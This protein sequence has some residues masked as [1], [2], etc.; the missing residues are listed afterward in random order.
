MF[1]DNKKFSFENDIY[2]EEFFSF[3]KEIIVSASSFEGEDASPVRASSMAVARKACFDILAR[4]KF[5]AG[6][7]EIVTIMT[8]AFA[9][10]DDLV[11]GFIEGILAERGEP[12]FEILLDSPDTVARVNIGYLFKYL[13]C[14]LKEIEK[15]QLRTREIM[16]GTETFFDDVTKEEVTVEW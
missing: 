12:F 5:N 7:K 1:E 8:E 3:I 9:K 10:D 6:L 16:K 11:K 15:D 14:R 4:C 13:L 2:S